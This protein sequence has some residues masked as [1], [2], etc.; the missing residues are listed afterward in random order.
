MPSRGADGGPDGRAPTGSVEAFGNDDRQVATFASARYRAE[1]GRQPPVLEADH[2]ASP[3]S[4]A[5]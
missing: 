3:G 1:A 4:P 2:V 5:T